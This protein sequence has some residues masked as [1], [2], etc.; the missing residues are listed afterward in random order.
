MRSTRGGLARGSDE[1]PVLIR[2]A[3][4]TPCLVWISSNPSARTALHARGMPHTCHGMQRRPFRPSHNRYTVHQ[5]AGRAHT[6]AIWAAFEGV[7]G[8]SSRRDLPSGLLLGPL[9][10]CQVHRFPPGGPRA[11][12]V[13][14]PTAAILCGVRIHIYIYSRYPTAYR[15][16]RGCVRRRA[17][18]S[19]PYSAVR[20]SLPSKLV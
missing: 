9:R 2:S 7:A 5:V 4:E 20:S 11:L 15:G 14:C 1:H 17:E 12:R 13:R 3:S 8:D 19:N 6:R 10:P 16:V 18:R